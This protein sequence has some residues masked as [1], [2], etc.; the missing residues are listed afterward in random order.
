MIL[1][2]PENELWKSFISGDQ[3]AFSQL[4]DQYS[5]SLFAFGMRYTTDDDLVKDCIHDLFIDLHSYRSGLSREVNVKFYLLK[6]FRRKLHAAHR[7]SSIFS[8]DR[9]NADESFG[10]NA[11]SFSIEHEIIMDESQREILQQ[12]ASEINQLP[13]RQREILYLKYN[14]DLDY[15]QIAAIMQISVPTCRTFIYRALKQLRGKLE[16]G[17]FLLVFCW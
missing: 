14:Q 12:L 2:L 10:M 7:K 4:Y 3:Q 13:D 6:S 16:F 8:I 15:D 17:S 5:D 1:T 9:W 11:F